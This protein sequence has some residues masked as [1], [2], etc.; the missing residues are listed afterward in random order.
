MRRIFFP[1]AR[2]ITART[3]GVTRTIVRVGGGIG[4]FLQV[5]TAAAGMLSLAACAAPHLNPAPGTTGGAAP[6]APATAASPD[7]LA[8][9]PAA[10]F[11]PTAGNLMGADP[12]KLE[13]WLGKPG[14]VRL[15]DPAQVWQYRAQGCVV[16]VYFYPSGGGMAVSHAEARSQRYAGDPMNPCLALLSQSRRKPIGS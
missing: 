8:S 11:T 15:D 6:S 3:I 5:V 9:A 12:A 16:D 7:E 14:L 2:N 13:R 10:S 1:T 4:K